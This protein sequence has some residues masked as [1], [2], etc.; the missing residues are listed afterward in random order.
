MIQLFHFMERVESGR[1]GCKA[2]CVRMLHESCCVILKQALQTIQHRVEFNQIGRNHQ[3]HQLFAFQPGTTHFQQVSDKVLNSVLPVSL[4]RKIK[5]EKPIGSSEI[6]DRFRFL[7]TKAVDHISLNVELNPSSIETAFS[8]DLLTTLVRGVSSILERPKS[9]GFR[10]T[11]TSSDTLTDWSHYYAPDSG[12][13]VRTLF[14]N[15]R[16]VMKAQ[17]NRLVLFLSSPVQDAATLHFVIKTLHDDPHY[18]DLFKLISPDDSTD[19][20]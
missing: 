16:Q 12:D 6:L 2:R 13:L 10:Y 18:E 1:C 19:F 8:Q 14:W 3:Q 17:L 15:S 5:L 11:T 20:T 4:N 9:N 7:L